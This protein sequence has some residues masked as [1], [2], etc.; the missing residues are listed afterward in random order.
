MPFANDA[1]YQPTVPGRQLDKGSGS[2]S[3]M[4]GR[5]QDVWHVSG[6]AVSQGTAGLRGESRGQGV[7]DFL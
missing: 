5:R 3:C 7:N 2:V 4:R 6:P 1:L